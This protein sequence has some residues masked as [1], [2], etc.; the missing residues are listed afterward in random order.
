MRT[1]HNKKTYTFLLILAGV[2]FT[3]GGCGGSSDSQQIM[4]GDVQFDKYIPL[5]NGK[6]VALFSNHTGI[7]GDSTSETGSPDE[8]TRF[9][10]GTDGKPLTYGEH[11]LDALIERGVNVAAIFSPEHGF[12]GN[13]DAGANVDNSIDEKTGVPILSLYAGAGTHYPSS[14]DMAKFDTIV[15][16]MQDVGLRY[17]T[18]YISM[19]YLMDACTSYG[20]EVIILDRPNPNG[21]YVDGP[22]LK[23][24]YE[25][26]VG[27]LPL[28]IVYGM[29]WGALAQ[30][31]NGEGW[32]SAGA[33]TCNLTVIPCAN[34]T[35][36]SKT[37]LI[38]NPSPN[39][40]D[41]RAVYLYAST[42]FFEN[43]KISVGRGTDF[44]FEIYG[45]P[46]LEGI[47][48]FDFTFT[49]RSMEGAL[50]PPFKD[51]VCYGVD[52]R[53]VPIDEILAAGIEPEYLLSAYNAYMSTS[54]E[55]SFWG[56][57]N[58]KGFYWID[59]L[60]GSDELRKMIDEGKTAMEIKASWQGDIAAFKEQRKPYLLYAE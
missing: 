5:L 17:Y 13:E 53:T 2:I 43:T 60:S 37:F 49:P 15:V 39:I 21:F 28:P 52:L 42:C 57:P 48:G 24:G 34:Y 26:G 56:Q 38:R 7:V 40:K 14:E 59:L 50:E 9:G 11:I 41:M 23:S 10:I 4:T 3:L 47:E 36:Q 1:Y 6:R 44:P 18:Y 35:H 30:M 12:R 29:T 19:Y 32:F 8:N 45:S 27:R 31:I 33:N 46:Y 20:K 55:E 25:S 22:I 54:P 16:D 58:A 51:E